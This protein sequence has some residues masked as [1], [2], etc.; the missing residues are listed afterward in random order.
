[1]AKIICDPK[2]NKGI[3]ETI[4]EIIKTIKGKNNGPT[5]IH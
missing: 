3:L 2:P 4:I 1:M 5:I